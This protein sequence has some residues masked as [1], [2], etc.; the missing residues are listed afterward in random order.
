MKIQKTFN[1]VSALKLSI[2]CCFLGVSLLGTTCKKTHEPVNVTLYEKDTLTI[3]KYIQG[4]WN[5][6]Y[7]KGGIAA[8]NIQYFNNSIAEFTADK[9]FISS[10]PFMAD[11]ISYQ[12]VKYIGSSGSVYIM[13]PRLLYFER[14]KNDTLIYSDA[15]MLVSEPTTYYLVKLQ[16]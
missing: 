14:I 9:K 8:N 12:W 16:N 11:T 1:L 2:F 13:E 3:Q 6:V 7:G 10:S 15:P 4:R 5:L